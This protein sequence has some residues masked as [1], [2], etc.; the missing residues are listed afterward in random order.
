MVANAP[1]ALEKK[2]SSCGRLVVKDSRV[3]A[4]VPLGEEMGRKKEE[5][6]GERRRKEKRRE[7]RREK[8]ERGYREETCLARPRAITPLIFVVDMSRWQDSFAFL[9]DKS[10]QVMSRHVMSRHVMSCHAPRRVA[11]C[12]LTSCYLVSRWFVFSRPVQRQF[13]F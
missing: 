1:E 3:F 2:A 4:E 9:V 7:E 5:R 12:H 13:V 8:R 11:S 10:C 6:R